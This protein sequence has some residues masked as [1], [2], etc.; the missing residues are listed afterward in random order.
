MCGWKLDVGGIKIYYR[1]IAAVIQID[2]P[3]ETQPSWT[4]MNI[5]NYTTKEL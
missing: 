5:Y 1:L 3:L 4:R 2:N